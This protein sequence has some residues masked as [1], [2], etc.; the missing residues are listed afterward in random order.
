MLT[1]KHWREIPAHYPFIK[2]DIYIIMPNHIHGIINICKSTEEKNLLKTENNI[3][4]SE[5][6]RTIRASQ[7]STQ[8]NNTADCLSNSRYSLSSF[9]LSKYPGRYI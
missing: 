5:N 1:D 4:P 8:I 6:R 3:D 2:L 9:H 7:R